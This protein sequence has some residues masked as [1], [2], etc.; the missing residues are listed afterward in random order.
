MSV[1]SVMVRDLDLKGV[2]ITPP[3]ANPPSDFRL[4]EIVA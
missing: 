1:S 2:Y 4:F 3:E